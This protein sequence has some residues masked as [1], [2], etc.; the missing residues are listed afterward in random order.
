MSGLVTYLVCRLVAAGI[1][2]LGV[3]LVMVLLVRALPGD[4]ARVVAGLLATPEQVEQ[5]R[6]S[7]GLDQPVPVQ[8][9]RYLVD[10]VH[11]SLGTSAR[12]RSEERRVGK[13]CRSRW[14]PYH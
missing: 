10:L 3:I 9:W 14:S 2:L 7:M 11:G 12:F 13:E 1:T 6:L 5:V 4:P 8:Y